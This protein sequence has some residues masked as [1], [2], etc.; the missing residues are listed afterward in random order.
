[1]AK[2]ER[3]EELRKLDYWLNDYR[4]R[5]N[6]CD[7]RI[8]D[9]EE[10]RRRVLEQLRGEAAGVSRETPPPVPDQRLGD[11]AGEAHRLRARGR[12]LRELADELEEA[13][14]RI[15]K[16]LPLSRLEASAA[17]PAEPQPGAVAPPPEE[18]PSSTCGE[19]GKRTSAPGGDPLGELMH[20]PAVQKLA[21]AV[22]ASLLRPPGTA[23][24]PEGN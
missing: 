22:L 3:P 6:H 4:I 8:A 16:L 10:R 12:A 1:M 20:S 2:R 23:Q 13:A 18:G 14:A 24:P 21:V 17:P 5:R 19:A 11:L 7:G 15:H 9:L